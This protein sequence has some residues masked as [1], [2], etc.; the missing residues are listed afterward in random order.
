MNPALVKN[1]V[2]KEAAGIPRNRIVKFGSAD[3]EVLLATAAADLAIGITQETAPILGERV[4][5]TLSGSEQVEAGAAVPRGSRVTTDTTGRAIVAAGGN[6]VVGIALE[7]A[8]AAGERIRV[9]LRA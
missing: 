7:S 2:C 9:L 4:D 6:T 1:F 8:T 3:G 5:V